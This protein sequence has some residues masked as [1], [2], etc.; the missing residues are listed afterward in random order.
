MPQASG[1]K[2]EFR[3]IGDKKQEYSYRKEMMVDWSMMG[4]NHS[5]KN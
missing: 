3:K 4:S 5:G 2:T 1:L